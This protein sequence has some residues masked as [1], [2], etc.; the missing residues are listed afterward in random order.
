[1]RISKK[2]ITFNYNND[3]IT[4][5]WWWARIAYPFYSMIYDL[6]FFSFKEYWQHIG[7]MDK[8]L[9]LAK[10]KGYSL[11]SLVYS[12]AKLNCRVG[13]YVLLF[14]INVEAKPASFWRSIPDRDKKELLED[15]VVLKCKDEAEIESL[16]NSISRDFAT[17]IGIQDGYVVYW[18][19]EETTT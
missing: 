2:G 1:M 12:W 18:N 14:D 6:K 7:R 9:G 15:L 19:E 10:I 4:W 16:C 5:V 17:A 13:H 11:Q 8:P 3:E